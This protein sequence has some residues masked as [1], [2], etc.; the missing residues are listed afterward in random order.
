M[1]AERLQPYVHSLLGRAWVAEG[2]PPGGLSAR[3]ARGF[4]KSAEIKA[5]MQHDRRQW[6]HEGARI[7]RG[8]WPAR[9]GAGRKGVAC[10]VLGAA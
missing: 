4:P 1:T 5:E 7:A 3:P 8:M 10:D 9:A 2:V 6:A